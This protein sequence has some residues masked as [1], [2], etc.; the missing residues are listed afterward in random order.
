M[1][2][3]KTKRRKAS[4][5]AIPAIYT[6][7]LAEITKAYDKLMKR[8]N[9]VDRRWNS[10]VFDRYVHPVLTNDH[11]PLTWRYDFDPR[12]NPYLMERLG[13]NAVLN[14]GAIEHEGRIYLMTRME[15]Y[16]RK[17]FFALA[18]SRDGIS[19]WT[20]HPMPIVMPE[21]EDPDTN[22]YDMRITRHADGHFYG[23]FCTERKDMTNPDLSAAT[24]QAGIA[25]SKDLIRWERLADL[26]T[27]SP[28]QRNVVLHPEF[29]EGKYAFYTR[30]QDGFISTGSGGGIGFG[31]SD[32]IESA[33]LHEEKIINSRAYHTITEAKNGAGATPIRTPRGWLHIAH[34]V[35][36]C[37][38]GLRYVLYAFVCDLADPS[39]AIATPG[40]YFLAPFEDERIGDVS[41][42]TFSNGAVARKDGSVL[43]YYGASD[44]RINVVTSTMDRLLDYC[45]S[46]PADPLRSAACVA[47]RTDLAL[48][49]QAFLRTAKGK[50]YRKV[51]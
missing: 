41:N 35:R 11:A 25:R 50:V 8:K 31:L 10:G 38:A 16:D 19:D 27:P 6:R 14:T 29:V 51:R 42:V 1:A 3:S 33:Q 23:V 46:T 49:N 18:S 44:T 40:G 26:K 47:Q 12:R 9:P 45:F 7:R 2:K 30:P 39:K 37:A 28:Q 43:I 34:G 13:V 21:T 32:S 4:A 48:R 24:A 17:S 20:W 22:V 5:D 15:G 36:N